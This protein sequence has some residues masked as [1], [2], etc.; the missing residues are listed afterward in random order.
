MKEEM[1]DCQRYREDWVAGLAEEATGCEECRSFCEEAQ[2][3]LKATA[4]PAQ[5]IPEFPEEYWNGFEDRLRARIVLENASKVHLYWKW[6]AMTAA[7]AAAV[8][9]VMWSGFLAVKP[10]VDVAQ[11]ERIEYLNDHIEGLDPMVVMFLEQSEMFLRSF[12]KI[13]PADIE[14]LADAY[15][16]ADQGLEE[17]TEQK[18]LAGDFVPVRITL[19]EY[20]SVL[21]EIRNLDS[22]EDL[23]A[24]DLEDIKRRIRRNGLIANLKAYQPHAV[25]VSRR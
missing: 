15:N 11:N 17:I 21:R 18:M 8:V 2:S 9:L 7:A 25:L 24:E 19:D 1:H 3:I 12:T 23:S 6:G 20:E 13:E 22:A 4:G 10:D 16:R 5:P 14:D